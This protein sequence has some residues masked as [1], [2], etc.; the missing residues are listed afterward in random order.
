MKKNIARLWDH[1][2]HCGLL[3][4]KKFTTTQKLPCCVL[5]VGN[6]A[7]GGRGKTP[8]VIKLAKMLQDGGWSPVVLTRGYGRSH[9]HDVVLESVKGQPFTESLDVDKVGD[10]AL[11]IFLKTGSVVLVS[12]NRYALANQYLK[13][14]PSKKIIFILD[15]GFQHW[16]LDRDWDLVLVQ[17]QDLEGHVFPGG[18]LREVPS[19]L[20]RAH[21]VFVEG[22]DFKKVAKVRVE[23]MASDYERA[24]LVTTRAPNIEYKKYFSNLGLRH[25]IELK[26]HAGVDKLQGAVKKCS[27]KTLLLGAKE[28]VKLFTIGELLEF[29]KNGFGVYRSP[30]GQDYEAVFV[31]LELEFSDLTTFENVVKG[32]LFERK[33]RE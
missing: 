14:N 9:H 23:L 13:N 24:A 18:Q 26:D 21:T 25:F 30:W 4:D 8:M 10:E 11:E 6:I 29:F 3:L 16:A 19:G 33:E 32:R 7:L 22:R 31:D 1:I 17:P 27:Q 5:S 12:K 28:A 15:D 2:Y 20:K